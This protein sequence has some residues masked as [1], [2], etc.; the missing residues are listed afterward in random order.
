MA[1]GKPWHPFP[2]R[3]S[4][5]NPLSGGQLACCVALSAD[6]M[7]PPPPL[8]PQVPPA[9]ATENLEP[10]Q[11]EDP[12]PFRVCGPRW[13]R[14]S[15]LLLRILHSRE[16]PLLRTWGGVGRHCRSS[17]GSGPL[18][19]A[20]LQALSLPPPARGWGL[21]PWFLTS[22]PRGLH[23]SPPILWNLFNQFAIFFMLKIARSSL[24][25][26]LAL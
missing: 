1:A 16:Q 22:L 19:G 21:P 24:S 5:S 14:P 3:V 10:G 18:Q 17:S 26:R 25:S 2:F 7:S 20:V 6:S 9:G 13:H 11:G 23:E 4:T 8:S 15:V 12:R